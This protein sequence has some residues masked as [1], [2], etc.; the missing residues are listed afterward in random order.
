M[1]FSQ[2]GM[3][4]DIQIKG[5][6]ISGLWDGF[7]SMLFPCPFW[8]AGRRGC[9]RMGRVSQMWMLG[10]SLDIL[11]SGFQY[12]QSHPPPELPFS[13]GWISSL[14][15]MKVAGP[16]WTHHLSVCPSPTLSQQ[17]LTAEIKPL[18]IPGMWL[19]EPNRPVQRPHHLFPSWVLAPSGA[20][21]GSLE[22]CVGQTEL[23]WGPKLH[24]WGLSSC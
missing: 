3:G 1:D 23:C 13:K 7:H 11:M 21:F 6:L 9:Q 10:M 16:G 4:V 19:R 2:L 24:S 18:L 14:W 17:M 20:W 15:I 12:I 22:P 5:N 8:G